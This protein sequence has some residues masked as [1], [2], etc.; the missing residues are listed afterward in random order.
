MKRRMI[1]PEFFNSPD[2]KALPIDVRLTY[3]GLW[4]FVDNNGVGE[5]TLA[6]VTAEL[7]PAEMDA[8][9][10]QALQMVQ[11]HLA[12]LVSTGL[13][14]IYGERRGDYAESRGNGALCV[15]DDLR[16]MRWL[17]ILK[18]GH[19]QMIDK[20]SAQG[21]CPRYSQKGHV[22]WGNV[23]TTSNL[24]G[25]STETTGKPD[26]IPSTNKNRNKNNTKVLNVTTEAR[27]H[28][29]DEPEPVDSPE[30]SPRQLAAVPDANMSPPTLARHTW[31]PSNEL[32]ARART[33][34]L[35]PQTLLERLRYEDAVAGAT[36]PSRPWDADAFAQGFTE[37][38]RAAQR[39]RTHMSQETQRRLEKLMAGKDADAQAEVTS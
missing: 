30:A 2:I 37:R 27:A 5:F 17:E 14:V 35:D 9:P 12:T 15:S 21:N 32:K 31:E 16:D 10:I 38:I 1:K 3:I 22:T 20:R 18:F 11:D 33:V 8:D 39:D 24:Q 4:C 29:N 25:N 13:I 34:G 6:K 19:H 28:E 26:G 23:K 7:Y 36:D